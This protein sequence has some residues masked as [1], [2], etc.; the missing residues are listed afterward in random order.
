MIPGLPTPLLGE[1][2]AITIT[3]PDLEASLQYYQHLGFKEILRADF[4]FPW[5][6][7]TDEALLIM[8]R[9]DNDPYLALTYYTKDGEKIAAVIEQKGI[10]FVSKPKPTDMV[11]RY[12]FQSPDGLNISVVTIPDGF[13]KPSGTTMLTMDQS[14]YFRPATYTNPVIGLFGELAQPVA[15]LDKSIAFWEQIGFRVLSKFTSPNPW[16]IL[17]DGLSI[18]GLHQSQEFSYPAITYFAADMKEK[19]EKLQEGG[20]ENF[21]EHSPGN[22]I[23]TTPEQQHFFLFKMGM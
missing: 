12:V 5:I 2:T 21:T 16:A 23:L 8:L 10:A 1:I 20:L 22:L 18:V 9:K 7:I 13:R 15:D 4:P 17:S 19:I 3:T 6:Q 14:D 11:K